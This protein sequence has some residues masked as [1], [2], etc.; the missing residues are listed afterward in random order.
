MHRSDRV[1]HLADNRSELRV[2]FLTAI[3]AGSMHTMPLLMLDLDNTLLPRD[4]AFT[5]WAEDFL[6]RHR[7]PRPN[8]NG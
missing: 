8:W 1:D 4:A 2:P 6:A 3:A 5:A 7:L